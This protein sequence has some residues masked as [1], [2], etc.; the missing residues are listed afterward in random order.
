MV[1]DI[2]FHSRSDERVC[3]LSFLASLHMQEDK[4]DILGCYKNLRDSRIL[5]PPTLVRPALRFREWSWDFMSP[6]IVRPF[7]VTNVCDIAV[8]ARRLGMTWKDFRPEDGIMRAEGNRHLI[9]STVARSIGI[10]LHYMNSRGNKDLPMFEDKRI[11]P[12]IVTYIPSSEADRMGFGI[13]P[14]FTHFGIPDFKMGTI[15]EVYETMNI[16]D[17]SGK[18]STTLRNVRGLVPRVTFGFSDLVPLA[19]P[20]L[21]RRG[22]TVIRL[23]IPSEYCVGLTCHTEGFMVFHHR[24]KEYI[25][26]RDEYPV[27]PQTRWVLRKYEELA[28]YPEW[29]DEVLANDQCNSRNL[30][31]LEDVHTCW[32]EATD[33]F[34]KIQRGSL[35]KYY[36][37]MASHI[38]H[39]VNYWGDAWA[40]LKGEDGKKAHDHYGLRDWIAEGAHMYWDYLPRIVQDIKNKGFDDEALVHEAWFTMMFRAFCWWRCHYLNPGQDMIHSPSI[41]PSRYWDSKL[42]VYIG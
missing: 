29:E 21:R 15:E 17:N 42:P 30:R 20:M 37:L 32:D 9:T 27:T 4:L 35:F 31:F 8:L 12:S 28:Q 1:D 23:P 11:L 18:A 40:H 25:S 6:D 38:R 36:D 10:I 33:Y 5:P 7:A 13:L 14:G 39:A 19:A 41:L 2:L 34:Y 22:S 16:L 26:S 24:L 3:W